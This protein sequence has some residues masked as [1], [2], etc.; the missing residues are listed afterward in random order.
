MYSYDYWYAMKYPNAKPFVGVR[1]EETYI[2][3]IFAAIYAAV[4]VYFVAGAPHLLRWSYPEPEPPESL[5]NVV[6][7]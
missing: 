5:S 4:A 1:P 7:K 2:Y 3:L 6:S